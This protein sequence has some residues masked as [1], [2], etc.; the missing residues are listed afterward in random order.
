MVCAWALLAARP[1]A[2]DGIEADF[3]A[4]VVSASRNDV[5]IPGAGGTQLSLVGD[6][7]APPTP[8]F[9]L[10]V[11]YR[12]GDRHLVSA[13]YAPLRIDATGVLSR[14]ATVAGQTY[15]AGSS[16]LGVYRF[17]SYRLTYR[18]SFVRNETV[19]VAGG[20][21][22]KLRDAEISIYGAETASKKNTGFVPLLNFHV[23]WRPGGGSLGLVLDADALAAPQGRAEDILLA[24]TWAA[25]D[26][27][28]L[29]IGYRM[30]EGGAD[31]DEVYNFAWLHY[32]VAGV[33]L[34]F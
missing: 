14:D 29:R 7:S 24:A 11:G 18:Y 23:G 16:L 5:R 19:E 26:R 25:S 12:F 10:R 34:R 9:R 1:A 30:V 4:G 21:T 8:V 32:A 6:L 22:A 17:D 31:N 3:E 27:M 15:A 33:D 2:A 28:V 13:L 20:L